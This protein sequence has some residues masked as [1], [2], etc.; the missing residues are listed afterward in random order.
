MDEIDNVRSYIAIVL[1]VFNA[2]INNYD[3][4]YNIRSSGNMLTCHFCVSTQNHWRLSL[5]DV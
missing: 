4:I 1:I 5:G 3:C 2:E